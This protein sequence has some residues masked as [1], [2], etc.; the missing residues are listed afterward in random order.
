MNIK[1]TTLLL[2]TMLVVWSFSFAQKQETTIGDDVGAYLKGC[3]GDSTVYYQYSPLLGETCCYDFIDGVF[4]KRED[5]GGVAF[6]ECTRS[7]KDFEIRTVCVLDDNN[8]N[9]INGYRWDSEGNAAPHNATSVMFTDWQTHINGTPDEISNITDNWSLSDLDFPLTGVSNASDRDVSS[10]ELYWAYIYVDQPM[11]LD[12][13]NGNTGEMIRFYLQDCNKDMVP[14]AQTE[15]NTGRVNRGLGSFK[16]LCEG[17][18][19]IAV[20]VSDYSVYGGF[21]LRYSTDGG[22]TFALFPMSQTFT[23]PIQTS[24]VKLYCYADGSTTLPN[25]QPFTGTIVDC[26]PTCYPITREPLADIEVNVIP[27]C[28]DVDGDPANY[29]SYVIEVV[30]VD[31]EQTFNQWINYG[32]DDTQ[33]PYTIQGSPVNCATGEPITIDPT[34]PLCDDVEFITAYAPVGKQGVNVERWNENAIRGEPVTTVPSEIFTGANDYSGMPAHVNGA[35][36]GPIVIESDLLVLNQ[37][38]DQSQ[39]RGWTYLYLTESARVRELHSRA[40][41]VDYFLGEC[42]ADPIKEA[43]GIHPNTTANGSVFDVILPAGIHY[44]G[45]EVFDFSAYSGISYQISYDNGVTW[46]RI[47]DGLLY[48]EKPNLQACT[49]KACIDPDGNAVLTD[50]ETGLALGS[51]FTLKQP[52]LCSPTVLINQECS[53]IDLYRVTTTLGGIE[54]QWTTSAVPI[55]GAAGTSYSTSFTATDGEGYPAHVNVADATFVAN[56]STT[57]NF[58][59]LHQAQTDGWIWLEDETQLREFNATSETSGVWISQDCGSNEMVEVLDGVYFNNRPNDLGTFQKGFYRV[60][61]YA[62]D[63]SA[64]G[65]TRLQ[66]LNADG[67]WITLPL[68]ESKPIVRRVKGWACEDGKLYS[69]DKSGSLDPDVYLC[70]DPGC[71]TS[72][73]CKINITE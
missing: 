36:D 30:N 55:S 13:N 20:Q 22:Q 10:Q 39:M 62:S 44:L 26:N 61:L 45:F 27:A 56:T 5:C 16:E 14:I 71:A 1:K 43:T 48:T 37:V 11:L 7:T 35:P 50:A 66:G 25:G 8:T 2:L 68:Y 12:D 34:A 58:S 9:G 67:N 47:P 4:V 63:F 18:Y 24:E 6:E 69:L 52:T 28:D 57:T 33:A 51:E 3:E 31:G 59:G 73:A 53:L 19:K 41:S 60:R 32:D 23:A 15:E 49:V 21:N 17:Y 70:Y 38:R 40:E 42:C 64:N 72:S 65:I 46:F 54:Q 29:V